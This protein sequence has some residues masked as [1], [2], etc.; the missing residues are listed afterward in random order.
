MYSQRD[1]ERRQ[2]ST[3]DDI[4]RFERRQLAR[5]RNTT[6]T[7]LVI[8][9]SNARRIVD[10]LRA[11][12]VVE[13]IPGDQVLVHQPSGHLFESDHSLV[14]FHIGWKAAIEQARD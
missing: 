9:E 14:L 4:E 2:D 6:P 5:D 10:D 11:D 3:H 13:A 1:H 8:D 12:D 7:T